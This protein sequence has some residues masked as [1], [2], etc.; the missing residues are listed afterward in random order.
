MGPVDNKNEI[1]KIFTP[2]QTQEEAENVLEEFRL[3]NSV[4]LTGHDRASARVCLESAGRMQDRKVD[5]EKVV[6]YVY[7]NLSS[8]EPA[9]LSS[10]TDSK[11]AGWLVCQAV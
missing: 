5:L 4:L 11:P 7:K 3:T 1:V 6:E 9:P 2:L 10:R 8:S